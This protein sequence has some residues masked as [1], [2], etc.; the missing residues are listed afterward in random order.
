MPLRTGSSQK[1]FSHNVGSEMDAGKPQDQALAIAFSKRREAMRRKKMWMGGSVAPDTQDDD[2]MVMDHYNTSGEPHTED[3][4]MVDH[5][6]EFMDDG[7]E[8]GMDDE[9]YMAEPSAH[10][11]RFFDALKRR[12]RRFRG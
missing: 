4:D 6:M 2:L 7:G 5:P 10:A 1:A 3:D 12:P 8:V 11:V 9:E